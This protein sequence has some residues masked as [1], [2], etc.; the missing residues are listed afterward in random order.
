MNI[1]FHALIFDVILHTLEF[2]K[3]KFEIEI[4][5]YKQIK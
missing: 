5:E 1:K 3:V 4:L 2:D